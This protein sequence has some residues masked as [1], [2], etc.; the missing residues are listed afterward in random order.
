MGKE[1]SGRSFAEYLEDAPLAP[2][3]SAKL[4]LTG[5]VR[6]S[7]KGGKFVFSS[8]EV[9]TV[10]LDVEAVVEFEPVDGGLTRITLD[11]AHVGELS[12]LRAGTSSGRGLAP[13]VMAT[14]HHASTAAIRAQIK[15][16]EMSAAILDVETAF[17]KDVWGDEGTDLIKDVSSEETIPAARFRF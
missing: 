8:P 6:R 9:G 15:K 11:A 10:E 5:E 1:S 13:F 3:A 14:P 16:A 17:I 7:T 12:A 4:I 2:D